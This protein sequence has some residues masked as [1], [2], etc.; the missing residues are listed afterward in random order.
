MNNEQYISALK[1]ALSGMDKASRDEILRELESYLQDAGDPESLQQ[2]FGAVEALAT[3]YLDGVPLP[4]SNQQKMGKVGKWV[5]LGVGG[6][7]IALMIIGI[8]I[9]TIFTGDQFDYAD[10]SAPSNEIPAEQWSLLEWA[11]PIELRLEQA[12]VVLYWHDSSELRWSCK[13]AAEVKPE[14]GKAIK[15]RHGF[16]VFYLP[17]VPA[18]IDATQADLVIVKPNTSISFEVVQSSVRVAEKNAKYNYRVE[19]QKSEF[20]GLQSSATATHTIT[21]NAIEASISAYK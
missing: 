3:Q 11:T 13:G 5:L 20:E 10:L 7:V 9:A 19:Q 17:A 4:L 12:H 16:C 15:V 2:R 8:G 1:R 18:L 6:V 14:P 21:I